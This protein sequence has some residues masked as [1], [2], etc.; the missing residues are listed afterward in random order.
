MGLMTCE[1]WTRALHIFMELELRPVTTISTNKKS[2]METEIVPAL[3]VDFK[4]CLYGS[5]CVLALVQPAWGVP[6]TSQCYSGR[7]LS[8]R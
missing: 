3:D 1:A 4:H 6:F 7:R 8:G 2:H 5:V